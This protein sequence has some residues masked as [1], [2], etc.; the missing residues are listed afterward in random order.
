MPMLASQNSHKHRPSNAQHDFIDKD[1]Q[2]RKND[3]QTGGGCSQYTP[4]PII[5]FGLVINQIQL[6]NGLSSFQVQ[7]HTHAS[8]YTVFL[9][10]KYARKSIP[11][12]PPL[13]LPR[14]R[15]TC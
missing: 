1:I 10:L 3:L 2:S 12:H 6:R 13:Q 5:L 14:H 8:S 4:V 11:L 15:R 9:S 7:A